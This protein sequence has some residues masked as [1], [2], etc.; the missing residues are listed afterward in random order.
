MDADQKMDEVYGY[1]IHQNLDTHLLMG[2]ITEDAI[3]WQEYW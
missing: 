1:H 3:I 2:G